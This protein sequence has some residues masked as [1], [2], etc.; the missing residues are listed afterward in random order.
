M[1]I[2]KVQDHF[3]KIKYIKNIFIDKIVKINNF[4]IRAHLDN[5]KIILII[6]KVRV[7]PKIKEF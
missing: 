5:Y 6:Y 2:Y 3:I 4:L 1:I 7:K